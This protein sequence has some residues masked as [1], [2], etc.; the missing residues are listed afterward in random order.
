MGD[1]IGA[2]DS[3]RTAVFAVLSRDRVQEEGCQ[4]KQ[5]YFFHRSGMYI[6]K[7]LYQ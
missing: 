6:D 5:D 3:I 4:Q 1:A 7:G 2:Y